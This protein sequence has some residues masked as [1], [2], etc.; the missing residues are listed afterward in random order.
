MLFGSPGY[1]SGLLLNSHGE[2]PYHVKISL[3]LCLAGTFVMKD[4]NRVAGK[5][6]N[7]LL[8]LFYRYE[9]YTNGNLNL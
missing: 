9:L 2:G 6:V 5:T 7:F 3:L 4:L 8:A 1:V